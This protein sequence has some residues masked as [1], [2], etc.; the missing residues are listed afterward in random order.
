MCSYLNVFQSAGFDEFYSGVLKED[1]G[2]VPVLM[3]IAKT[4]E[5]P[6][7]GKGQTVPIPRVRAR[8]LKQ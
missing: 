5:V 3:V 6:R 7:G 4:A 8:E 1:A 2:L